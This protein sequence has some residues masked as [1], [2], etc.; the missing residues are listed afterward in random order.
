MRARVGE[1]ITSPVTYM[2]GLKD[3]IVP[4]VN[5][6]Y[7]KKMLV[8]SPPE[9]VAFPNENHFIPWTKRDTISRIILRYSGAQF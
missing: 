2:Y 5:V 4:P 7:A 6:E 9:I 3:G 8:N 1:K